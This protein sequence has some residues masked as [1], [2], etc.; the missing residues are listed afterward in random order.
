MDN[1]I[2][3][4]T[5]LAT[6]LMRAL[7]SRKDPAPLFDDPWGDRLVPESE[8]EELRQQILARM[9]SDA[10]AAALRVPESWMITCEPVLPIRVS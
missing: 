3:S 7:H 8:R 6:A 4:R 2:A 9:D 1:F 10:R 5:A